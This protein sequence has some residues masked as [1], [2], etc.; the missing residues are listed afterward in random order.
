MTSPLTQLEELAG[1]VANSEAGVIRANAKGELATLVVNNLPRRKN[2]GGRN[3][4][5]HR[6]SLSALRAPARA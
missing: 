5:L 1:I 3:L 4:R 6:A 2:D